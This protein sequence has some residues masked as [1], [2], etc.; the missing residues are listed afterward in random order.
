MAGTVWIALGG[1]KY[2]I[3][4][5]PDPRSTMLS[6]CPPRSYGSF[7]PVAQASEIVA[8]RWVPLIL[9]EIMVGYHH[10]N[11][12]RHALP[13]ISPSVLSQRLRS[14]EEDGVIARRGDPGGAS[15]H[16]TEAGE[17]LRPVIEALGQW[18]RRWVTRD[19]REYEL[20]PGVLMWSL[21]RHV[22]TAE[23]PFG[24]SV[25]HFRL[26]GPP[27]NR[28]YWWLVV[29]RG[30]SEEVDV[31]MA[32]PGYPVTLTVSAQLRVLVDVL[33]HDTT[34]AAALRQ[35]T[36]ALHGDRD[37]ARRFEALFDFTGP[38]TFTGESLRAAGSSAEASS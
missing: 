33:M 23:F 13:L 15:Y 5:A 14:L 21:R 38:K 3:R 19:Y 35:G 34:L 20:D 6:S 37:L 17:E 11:E 18:A 24:R 29:E 22:V 8:Q 27:S 1:Y 4:T 25:V 9:R 30:G 2:E 10:F 36:I 12:I 32:D 16:L 7:C 26:D 28:R 31:C